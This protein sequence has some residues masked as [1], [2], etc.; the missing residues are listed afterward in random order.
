MKIP[1]AKPF[2]L[3]LKNLKEWRKEQ[4]LKNAEHNE[5]VRTRQVLRRKGFELAMAAINEIAGAE[6]RAARRRMTRNRAAL[7]WAATRRVSNG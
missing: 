5:G 4:T 1:L 6:P 3:F 7:A 2:W